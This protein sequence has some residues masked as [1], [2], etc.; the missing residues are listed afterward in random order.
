MGNIVTIPFL[1]YPIDK[2]IYFGLMSFYFIG[3]SVFCVVI[4]DI[5]KNCFKENIKENERNKIKECI[6]FTI[7]KL[8]LRKN[9]IF[10]LMFILSFAGLFF[11]KEPLSSQIKIEF[12]AAVDKEEN[13]TQSIMRSEFYVNAFE[14]FLEKYPEGE[15]AEYAKKI[16]DNYEILINPF[17]VELKQ[18]RFIGEPQKAKKLFTLDK[19]YFFI[20]LDVPFVL[21]ASG[22]PLNKNIP[23]EISTVPGINKTTDYY[24][25]I[26]EDITD[27]YSVININS[28]S[29]TKPCSRKDSDDIELII[30][31]PSYDDVDI[32]LDAINFSYNT[33]IPKDSYVRLI[34]TDAKRVSN[35]L[36]ITVMKNST[37]EVIENFLLNQ[38][39]VPQRIDSL[40]CS[41]D[42]GLYVY[43]IGRENR[44]DVFRVP[45]GEKPLF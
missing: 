42:G 27:C 6:R 37:N 10:Y 1:S 26:P 44:Y 8:N 22:T 23:R 12:S 30:D 13:I 41:Y 4:W 45:Y 11:V 31:N 35:H 3:T 21:S 2:W 5:G 14:D 34:F 40:S 43:N 29:K 28:K 33:T 19:R 25:L 32:L 15:Y 16:L 20:C 24:L 39:G 36:I 17:V 7:S 38:F 18:G 9:I